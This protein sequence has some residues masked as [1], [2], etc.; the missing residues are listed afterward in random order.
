MEALLAAGSPIVTG[1]KQRFSALNHAA[2]KGHVEI[3]KELLRQEG[4]CVEA[5]SCPT[6][7]SALLIAC[8][9][10][11]MSCIEVLLEAGADINRPNSNGATSLFYAASHG[12][13]AAV[14]L[15]LARGARTD[16]WRSC[17][18]DPLCMTASQGH[19]ACVQALVAAGCPII[20]D[21][22]Y[23]FSALNEA[24]QYGHPEI[25]H[26]L[27]Q[28]G[29][30]PD[31]ESTP[32]GGA[33]LLIA[34]MQGQLPCMQVL[35]NDGA[36]IN[37]P[38]ADGKTA[39]YWAAYD[40]SIAALELLLSRH[41]N[42]QGWQSCENDPL[43]IAAFKGHIA[44]V[45]ALLNAGAPIVSNREYG[46]SALY[47][48]IQNGHVEVFE[49]LLQH[50]AAA[51]AE[52]APF[53]T[54]PLFVAVA[55]GQLACIEPLL[56]AGADV[57]HARDGRT[58]LY[59]AARKGDGEVLKLLLAHGANVQGWS[60]DEND[61]LCT[62]VRYGRLACVQA[63]LA[64]GALIGS[65]RQYGFNALSRAALRGDVKIL[66]C[67]LQHGAAANTESSPFGGPPLLLAAMQGQLACVATL[68]AAGVD[69]AGPDSNGHTALHWAACQGHS[70]VVT[71]LLEHGAPVNCRSASGETPL[72]IACQNGHQSVV[73]ALLA[74][75]AEHDIAVRHYT[76]V[77]LAAKGCHVEIVDQ[78]LAAG[79]DVEQPRGLARLFSRHTPRAVAQRKMAKASDEATKERYAAVLQRLQQ[80]RIDQ[81]KD[82][83]LYTSPSPRDRQK[84]RMPSS[85]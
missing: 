80:I 63:L 23:G 34:A 18:S 75:G 50:G 27:L 68:L 45:K 39:L 58:P 59:W 6:G 64:A 41:A 52:S 7:G 79:A 32:N 25:L 22:K 66:E 5:D 57:N 74:G 3:L 76:P 55:T 21:R 10:G 37:R 13:L 49:L 31:A 69:I 15:L 28:Q 2:Q 11:H 42:V 16:G 33:P 43:Y 73:Q 72:S 26:Y 51:N 4:V 36:D 35:L 84:S 81:H 70:A 61:P 48:A 67:L 24:A 83:L 38:D 62:A 30:S 46:F 82:C 53:G 8:S 40:G 44:C 20:V 54:T 29:A 17:K 12:H 85:A 47:G 60:C 1:S 65:G 77:Y 71:Y 14:K 56:T 9:E 19:T 78:L